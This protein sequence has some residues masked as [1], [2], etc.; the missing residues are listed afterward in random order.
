MVAVTGTV[1]ARSGAVNENLATGEIEVRATDALRILSESETPPFPI[2]E[3]CKTKEEL[4]LKYRYLDLRRPD[5]QRNLIMRSKVATLT[6]Q[7]LADEGFLEIET[8]MLG[9]STPEGARD[10]LVP[11]RDPSGK[12]LCAAAVST[13]VQTAFDVFRL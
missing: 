11:S 9:K 6:R 13:A 4:R 10:Y 7:F 2:E 12:F 3:N 8:P 1:A 5:L